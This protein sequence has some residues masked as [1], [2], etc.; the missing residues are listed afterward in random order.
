LDLNKLHAAAMRAKMLGDT[1][2][3]AALTAQIAALDRAAEV[4]TMAA[5]AAKRTRLEAIDGEGEAEAEAGAGGDGWAASGRGGSRDGGVR[6]VAPLDERGIP[7]SSLA[8]GVTATLGAC[9]VVVL[10]VAAAAAVRV[11]R[12]TRS[13]TQRGTT[14]GMDGAP[15]CDQATWIWWAPSRPLRP[16][17]AAVRVVA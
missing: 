10:G 9:C 3:L 8:S 1:A 6:L 4:P 15:A 2:K 17:Q 5:T 12:P 11:P 14:C 7:L 16:T 13:P